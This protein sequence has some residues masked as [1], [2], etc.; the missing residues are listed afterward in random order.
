MPSAGRSK[1]LKT[2]EWFNS[3]SPGINAAKTPRL[4]VSTLRAFP[5][6]YWI[7]SP[8]LLRIPKN[9]KSLI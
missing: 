2:T 9:H 6:H 4:G 5:M 3:N 7:I 1:E 8:Y